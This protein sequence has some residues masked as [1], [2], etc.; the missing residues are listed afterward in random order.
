MDCLA[1]DQ[2]V[3]RFEESP[4]QYHSVEV[5]LAGMD[6]PYQ[7]KIWNIPSRSMC[8]LIRENSNILPRLRVGDI[9]EMKYYSTS[10]AYTSEPRKTVIREITRDIFSKI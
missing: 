1:T 7:F 9:L 3:D 5:E 2:N 10:S 8:F 4:V 6:Y